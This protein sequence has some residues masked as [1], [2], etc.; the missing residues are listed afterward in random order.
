MRIEMNNPAGIRLCTKDKELDED[1][2][3][4]PT[5]DITEVETVD[6][7]IDD[8]TAGNIFLLVVKDGKVK[9]RTHE[10]H[11]AEYKAV[12][13]SF[14]YFACDSSA[15]VTYYNEAFTAQPE[16]QFD[17]GSSKTTIFKVSESGVMAIS[18]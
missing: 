6:I 13:D 7:R 11:D 15:S 8:E 16:A 4:V 1:I 18:I 17:D 3:V 5:F 12:K 10:D 2:Q 14:A 9:L